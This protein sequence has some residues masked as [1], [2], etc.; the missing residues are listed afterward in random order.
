MLTYRDNRFIIS[1]DY[2]LMTAVFLLLLPLEWSLAWLIASAVHELCHI[3]VLR[4]LGVRIFLVSA[5]A[6]G[7]KIETEA[8]SNYKEIL[9]ALA[10]PVGGLCLVTLWR[11]A[12]QLSICAFAQ[13]TFNLIPVY[14]FDGGRVL[15]G[16][17]HQIFGGQIADKLCGYAENIVLILLLLGACVG[18]AVLKLGCLPIAI[19]LIIFLKCKK[20]KIPCKP[21]KQIVQ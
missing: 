9:S 6:A 4:L 5:S 17:I 14:P 10:G 19:A 1:T 15:R 16:C 2:Y 13:S 3:A 11:I 12:P 18:T 21:K 7:I 8:M 20:I